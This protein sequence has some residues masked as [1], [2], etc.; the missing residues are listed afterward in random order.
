MSV[1]GGIFRNRVNKF[2]TK[3][4]A[5][6]GSSAIPVLIDRMTQ[7]D[8]YWCEDF[9]DEV[10]T[11]EFESGLQADFWTT[12][13]TNYA[14]GNVTYV[15]DPGGSI[16]AKCANAD[17]DSVTV[18]GT[19]NIR[20]ALNP[21]MEAR[22]KI[23]NKATAF[24]GVG[25]AE[26]AFVDKASPDDDIFLVG[27]D[28]DAVAAVGTITMTGV[29]TADETFVIDTQ[30]FTW[31]TTR[32]AAG[33]VTIG[34]NQAAAVTNICTAVTADLATVTATDGAGDT[35]VVTS[36]AK[37]ITGNDIVFTEASTNMAVDGAGTLGTTTAGLG[38]NFGATHIVSLSNDA[39]G[40]AIYNDMG[41]AIVNDTYIKVKIDLTDTEQPRVWIDDVEVA[42]ASITGTVQAGTTLMPYMMVQN[43]AAGA[44]QR[45]L[46][47]D[48]I[49]IWQERG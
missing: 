22:F 10:A 30:T 41:V 36:V 1:I 7:K 13:G 38:H 40:G 24:M 47:V 9:D 20:V 11:V 23:D 18:L 43:L 27:I 31:K 17:N 45:I 48:Y 2:Y 32:A 37:G 44:I 39:N 46:T 12:A 15:A 14:A 49:K 6:R 35:V 25:F 8:Y 42:P 33:Q 4:I 29:A 16:D 19:A 26:G 28:S 5:Y 21:V 34:A 3:H